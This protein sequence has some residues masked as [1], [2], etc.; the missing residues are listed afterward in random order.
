MSNALLLI[1]MKN[2]P[3]RY[4]NI[5]ISHNNNIS[6]VH[7]AQQQQLLKDLAMIMSNYNWFWP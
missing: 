1:S 4:Y 7:Q 3:F 2:L 5:N 6:L